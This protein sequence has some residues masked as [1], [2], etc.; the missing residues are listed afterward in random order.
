MKPIKSTMRF[1]TWIF[2]T[3]YIVISLYLDD[4]ELHPEYVL[5][6]GE[7]A[8]MIVALWGIHCFCWLLDLNLAGRLKNDD[9]EKEDDDEK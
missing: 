3:T 7:C 9:T 1:Y 5:H 6:V 4:G 8:T 2:I